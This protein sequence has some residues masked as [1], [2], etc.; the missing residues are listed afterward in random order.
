[1][2]LSRNVP[3]LRS[4]VLLAIVVIP[5][6][7]LG[8]PTAQPPYDLALTDQTVSSTEV[9]QACHEICA[10]DGFRI[11]AAGRVTLEAGGSVKLGDGFSVDPG[12]AL[13]VILDPQ[14]CAAYRLHGLNFSPYIDPDEDPNLGDGQI[15]PAELRDRM[16]RVTPY[17]RA[18]RTFGCSPDLRDAGRVAHEL[19]LEAA[20]GAWLA[21]DP[22][23]N[24]NQVNCLIEEALAGHVDIAIVGSEV[25][26]RGDLTE[27]ELLDFIAQVRSALSGSG[28]NIPVTTAD[29]HGI[30]LAHP[31]VLAAVDVVFVNYYPYWEGRRVDQ[32]MAYVHQLHQEVQQAAPGK[33]VV[34]SEAGWPSCGN[35][36]AEAVPSP[37]NAAFYFLNFVSWARANEVEYFYFEAFDEAW[38]AAHEGPQGACWGVWRGDG[39]LKDGMEAVFDGETLPDNWT[40]PPSEAVID[41]AALPEALSTNLSTFLVTGAT[42]PANLVRI[43]GAAVPGTAMDEAGNFAVPVVLSAGPNPIELRIEGPDGVVLSDVTR[44]VTLDPGYSTAGARLIYVDAVDV[45]GNLPELSGTIVIDLDR[46]SL[47]GLLTN[48]HVRGISPD[49]LEIYTAARTVIATDSHQSLRTL[50]F[51]LEILSNGFHVAPDGARLYAHDEIVDVA[52][53]QLLPDRLPLPIQTSGSWSSAPLPGDPAYSAE[54]NDL[55]CRSDVARIDLGSRTVEETRGGQNTFETDLALTPDGGALLVASYSF[56]AGRISVYDPSDLGTLARTVS[57]L[58]DFVGEI[59]FSADGSQAVVGSAGN[60]ASSTGGRVT[61]VDLTSWEVID[62]LT[63][64]LADNLATSGSNE[65]FVA[66]GESGVARRLGIQVLVLAPGGTLTRSKTYF[67]GINRWVSAAGKPTHDRIRKIVFKPA[68]GG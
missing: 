26:L 9:F 30:L 38:K 10:G 1:M 48:E 56:A 68:T 28:R 24:Q 20:V 61:V 37:T 16:E 33:K 31:A 5:R 47:L 19:A 63:V 29:V 6:T 55:Y 39:E 4:C 41:F 35:I 32:A 17:T 13:E 58:G 2:P 34:V 11:T 12:G 60:P 8:S 44:T 23:E 40:D 46:N 50:P 52:T 57:G 59:A 43:D 64:P 25:L 49:G 42:D 21:R 67:L 36:I 53:N 54:G 62:Q 45:A 7:A 51:S 27:A 15:T 22:V 66:S 65:F 18:I 3:L 14:V